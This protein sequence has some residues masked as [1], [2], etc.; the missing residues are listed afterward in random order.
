[1]SVGELP[2]LVR[3][4]MPVTCGRGTDTGDMSVGELPTRVRK[5]L[6][7]TYRWGTDTGDMFIR[8]LPTLVRERLPIACGRGTN[9]GQ[10]RPRYR[11]VPAIGESNSGAVIFF[12]TLHSVVCEMFYRKLIDDRA[13][14]ESHQFNSRH[15][16]AF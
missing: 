14:V 2:T 9:T 16:E 7:V 1:M 10:L 5:R 8:E 6:P 15:P 4:R 12:G 3:K 13:G 11:P